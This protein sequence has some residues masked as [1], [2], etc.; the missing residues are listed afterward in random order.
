MTRNHMRTI[1]TLLLLGSTS[2]IF[3]QI[4]EPVSW[5]A[6]LEQLSENEWE[7]QFTANIDQGWY[8]YGQDIEE[9]GPI[10]T[11]ILYDHADDYEWLGKAVEIGAAIKGHDP[12][13]DMPVT[14]YKDRLQIVQRFK[15]MNGVS[16][17]AGELE[18]MTCD[19]QRCLPPTLYVFELDLQNT[20]GS[21]SMEEIQEI[22]DE[23]IEPVQWTGTIQSIAADQY[24][25]TLT[26][27][28]ESGWYVYSNSMTDSD[29]PL[30][31]IVNY[32]PASQISILQTTENGGIIKTEHDE[33]FDIEVTKIYDQIEIIEQ[34]TVAENLE[35]VDI[36][37]EYM[38]C[39]KTECVF[40][41][42]T[43]F[44][45]N[46]KTLTVAPKDEMAENTTIDPQSAQMQLLDYYQLHPEKL[47]LEQ[48]ETCSIDTGS[49]TPP[50]NQTGNSKIFL[51]GFLGGLIA[52]LTPCVFPM[53]P[54]T[55]SFFTKSNETKTRGI[56]NAILYGGFI[57]LIYVLLSLPFHF[58]DSINPDILNNISTNVTLNIIFFL[59][60]IFFAFSFF[61]YYELTL[62]SSWTNKVSQAEGIGGGL[63]IF[64]MAL[65]LALVSF[66]CTGPILGS[67]LAGSL[68]SNGGA[69]QLTAGMSGFGLA[70]A[71]PFGLFA[72][73]PSVMKKLP[74]SGNWMNTL[75]V[76][77]GFLELALAF[78]FL[79][80]ADLVKHWGIL[81]IE[82]FLGIWMLISLAMALYLFGVIRFPHDSKS[83][84]ITLGRKALGI[85]SIIITLYLASGFRYNNDSGTFTSLTLLSG[86]APPVGY[87]WFHPNECPNNINCFKD[88]S[89]GMAYAKAHNKPIML[90]FTGYACVNCRKMEEHVWP[91]PSIS[92]LLKDEYVLISLYV[93]DR[94][95]LE[96]T[97]QISLPKHNGGERKL[98]TVGDKWQFFQTEYFKNNSQPLYVLLNPE[99]EL[100]NQ[101]VGYTPDSESFQQ[102]LECGLSLFKNKDIGLQ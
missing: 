1:F 81:K 69:M 17:I 96:E 4:L 15:P 3:A 78:K 76:I 30:P 43:A 50:L 44:V 94:T 36:M 93:D 8:V 37:V 38:S 79:S 86:I 90:D 89:A 24:E 62:P 99:G 45:I 18:Y 80:N 22:K 91:L 87:S 84:K 13:F 48:A 59:V 5:Q 102:F 28:V 51:L 67:L 7:I 63:G 46:L 70:L 12:I 34:F 21:D 61:G 92:S 6:H 14:K 10:P 83:Q 64:F 57:F 31:T 52:L 33:I 97:E 60:F 100:L 41:P 56:R 58:V 77:M 53:I 32:D 40:P 101:P 47:N 74:K 82:P 9:G 49:L 68:T 25:L 55:V 71:L 2:I 95:E 75:K 54:L 72:A 65:T 35:Q 73:F 11:S 27:K 66:S 20:R 42:P 16:K 23:I 88:L 85:F 98:K 29:G 26:G 39:S 19:D